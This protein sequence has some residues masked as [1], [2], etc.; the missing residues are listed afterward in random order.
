MF[1]FSDSF[2]RY[3]GTIIALSVFGILALVSGAATVIIV[4][5]SF[6]SP[7]V[8]TDGQK[9][10][11]AIGPAGFWRTGGDRVYQHTELNPPG[12]SVTTPY[13]EKCIL[14]A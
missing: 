7:T 9:I 3:L 5:E 8:T 13:D 1:M 11:A 6:E 10:S 2:R 4:D 14:P 12:G